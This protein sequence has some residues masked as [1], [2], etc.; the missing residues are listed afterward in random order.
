MFL[1]FSL[2]AALMDFSSK[3]APS[4]TPPM[5]WVDVSCRRPFCPSRDP[6]TESSLSMCGFLRSRVFS[7]DYGR[8]NLCIRD[9]PFL[10]SANFDSPV[11][12]AFLGSRLLCWRSFVFFH[13]MFL[14]SCS[15]P[16]HPLRFFL[17]FLFPSSGRPFF[18][19]CSNNRLN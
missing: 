4:R 10:F 16:F 9:K 11:L 3:K 2:S 7:L 5:I 13:S 17:V 1:C 18:P 15:W 12:I 14:F 19:S 8:R 6:L